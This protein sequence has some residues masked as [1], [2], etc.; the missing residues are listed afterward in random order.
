[1]SEYIKARPY[2][3]EFAPGALQRFEIVYDLPSVGDIDYYGDLVVAVE[4]CR[5]DPENR[6]LD[7]RMERYDFVVVTTQNVDDRFDLSTYFYAFEKYSPSR[8]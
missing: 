6:C 7:D 3:N 8:W 2:G 1:M 5:M 4:P